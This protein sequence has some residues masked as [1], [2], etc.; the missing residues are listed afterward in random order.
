[1]RFVSTAQMRRFD[2]LANERYGIPTLLLMENAGRGIADLAEKLLGKKK[3]RILIVCGKGNNGGDGFVAAR[4][5]LNRGHHV[6]VA[7]LGLRSGLKGDTA[8]NY[9]I[10]KKMS[11]PRYEITT[12]NQLKTLKH[13]SRHSSLLID[14]IFGTGLERNI[15]GFLNEAIS[16]MNESGK[17]ILS[18][19]IPSGLNGDTGRVM[20]IAVRANVT[21][22][23]GLAKTGM[24]SKLARTFTGKIEVLDISLPKQLM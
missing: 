2:Q 9:S 23:L 5:L 15:S 3:S 21:G 7:L 4:H 12:P 13:E 11:A 24:K 22:T 19:D 18:V 6:K 16:M 14:A 20:G 17:K 10:L 8:L 1:M